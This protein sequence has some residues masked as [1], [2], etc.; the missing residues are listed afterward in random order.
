MIALK[1]L[2]APVAYEEATIGCDVGRRP[3]PPFP[4]LKNHGTYW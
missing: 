3:I 2:D 4:N 1:T